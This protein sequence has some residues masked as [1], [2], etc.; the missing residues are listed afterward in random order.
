[1]R[2][3]CRSNV[4]LQ[5]PMYVVG[6]Q[7]KY[8]RPFFADDSNWYDY[9][10]GI[11][12]RLDPASGTSKTLVEYTSPPEVRAEAGVATLFKSATLAGNLLYVCTQTEVLIY[13]LPDLRQVNYISLP[14]FNDVH[15]VAPTPWGTLALAVAGLDLVQEVS[16]N[17]EMLRTWDVLGEDSWSKFS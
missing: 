8:L 12:L 3:A 1:N 6:G 16:L 5:F 15:H 2:F 11:I 4:M 13:A 9:H 17:G 14:C 7:Q 10:K